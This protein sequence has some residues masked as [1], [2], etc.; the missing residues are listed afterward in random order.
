V[1]EA[2]FFS[3]REDFDDYMKAL[4]EKYYNSVNLPKSPYQ[5]T[6]PNFGGKE[7]NIA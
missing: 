5:S 2:K 7:H 3:S 1:N 6:V 4:E